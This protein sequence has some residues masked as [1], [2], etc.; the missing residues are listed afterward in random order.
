MPTS[1]AKEEF[2]ALT[3]PFVRHTRHHSDASTSSLS[4]GGDE[5]PATSRSRTIRE[6][7]AKLDSSDEDEEPEKPFR[8]GAYDHVPLQPTNT[9]TGPKGVIKDAWEARRE[10]RRT[11]RADNNISA[12][13]RVARDS[14]GDLTIGRHWTRNTDE[15]EDEDEELD[16]DDADDF[17]RKWK[18]QRMAEMKKPSASHAAKY[19]AL[20]TVDGLGYLEAVES[21][22]MGEVVVVYIYD[23]GVSCFYSLSDKISWDGEEYC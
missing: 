1:A 11:A 7:K 6:R 12:Q 19:G 15:S 23:A 21:A 2:D 16:D 13:K 14:G 17:M 3:N 18:E 22:P 10:S 4:S 9:N 8:K 5:R 20:E